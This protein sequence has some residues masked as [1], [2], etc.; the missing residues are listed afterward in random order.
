MGQ[1]IDLLWPSDQQWYRGVIAGFDNTTGK[2]QLVYDEGTTESVNFA[3]PM[4]QQGG[5][6]STILWRPVDEA[7]QGDEN[8]NCTTIPPMDQRSEAE[9][10]QKCSR[11]LNILQKEKDAEIFSEAVDPREVPLY[12]EIILTPMDLGTVATRLS[13]GYYS[14]PGAH[15]QFAE[16]VRLVWKNCQIFNEENSQ[17]WRCAG[18]LSRNFESLYKAMVLQGNNG[19]ILPQ[20]SAS[21]RKHCQSGQLHT[22]KDGTRELST[23][24][25]K[26]MRT[27]NEER[28]QLV[29]TMA[30]GSSKT[31]GGI[32]VARLGQRLS[33]RAKDKRRWSGAEVVKFNADATQYQVIYDNLSSEWLNAD[34]QFVRPV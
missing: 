15:H 34:Y 25:A 13:S 33:I 5:Q 3:Q 19:T 9:Q 6:V 10:L 17:I 26:R 18:K 27:S 2:H 8:A 4:L 23:G 30:I 20:R 16:D 22:M 24:D 21:K 11:V 32:L 28:K 12:S 1:R 14:G 31:R 29:Q 7:S